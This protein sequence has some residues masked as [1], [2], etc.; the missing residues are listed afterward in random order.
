MLSRHFPTGHP[1][2]HLPRFAR[3]A[4]PWQGRLK[5]LS[6]SIDIRHRINYIIIH[7]L[8]R[9]TPSGGKPKGGSGCGAR[10]WLSMLLPGGLGIHVSWDYDRGGRC[11]PG[12][13]QAKAGNARSDRV[14]GSLA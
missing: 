1:L 6:L 5:I 10:E 4:S 7:P 13:G 3:L 2:P 12:L 8:S 9:R 14:P 11:F